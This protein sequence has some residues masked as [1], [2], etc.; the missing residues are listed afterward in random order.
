MGEVWYSNSGGASRLC[1]GRNDEIQMADTQGGASMTSILSK[2]S[3]E[4]PNPFFI[5]VI[6][7]LMRIVDKNI[8]DITA[9]EKR[10]KELEDK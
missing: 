4:N 5:E 7:R 1:V 6:R 9:L 2:D 10:V 8:D 3:P